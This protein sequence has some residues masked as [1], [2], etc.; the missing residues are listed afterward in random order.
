VPPFSGFFSKD[1]ILAATLS[2]SHANVFLFGLGVVVAVLTTFYMFRLLFVVF[3]GSTR[4]AKPTRPGIAPIMTWPLFLL[5][6][7]SALA[8]FWAIDGI[9]GGALAEAGVAEHA[10]WAHTVA[11]LASLAA[12]IT[13]FVLAWRCIATRRRIRCR[14][15]WAALGAAMRDRFY[16]DEFTSPP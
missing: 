15:S 14:R 12:V 11:M 6:V 2:G 1:A 8:G 4:S 5:A 10:G 7:P 9:Y 3:L 16:L 13:G